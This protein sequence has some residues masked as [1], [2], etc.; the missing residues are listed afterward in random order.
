MESLKLT[1]LE[2]YL[3]GNILVDST[4]ERIILGSANFGWFWFPHLECLP[5]AS[6][7]DEILDIAQNL[8]C[9]AQQG[10]DAVLLIQQ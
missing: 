2:D 8:S 1:I 7:P 9:L 6:G 5:G 3:T 10:L 4:A